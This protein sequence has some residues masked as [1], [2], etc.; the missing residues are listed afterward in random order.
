M[1]LQSSIV[2]AVLGT[3]AASDAIAQ[4]IPAPPLSAT[5]APAASPDK[6][7]QVVAQLIADAI[8]REYE[9]KQDWGRQKE[10]TTGLHSYGNFFKFDMH[11]TKTAVNHGVWKHY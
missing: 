9:R 3:I 1:R 11:R 7:A 10:I 4:N 5:P 8:P 2:V 6:I